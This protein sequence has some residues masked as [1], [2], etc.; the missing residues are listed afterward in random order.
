GWAAR[1]VRQAVES[2]PGI[3]DHQ[4]RDTERRAR[5]I[6]DF[7]RER[8]APAG[9]AL[10]QAQLVIARALG[11]ASWPALIG[12]VEQLVDRESAGS[13]FERAADA[14]VSGDLPA[15]ERLLA[16]HPALVRERSS[17]EHRATLLHYVS[18]NGV[19]SWRQK[20]PPNAVDVARLL[21]DAGA[22]VDAEADV[23]G[24]GATTLGLVVTSAHPRAAG[25]QNALADLLL[26][27]GARMHARVAWYCLMNGCPEAAAHVVERG[28]PLDLES[29]AGIGRL[30]YV[31]RCFEPPRAPSPA[32]VAAAL[33]MATW[34]DR[35]DVVRHLLDRG[36]NLAARD[37]KDGSTP[38]HLAAYCG[39]SAVVE[40]LLSR[41]A[42]VDALDAERA[43]PLAWVLHAR[44]E[45]RRARGEY[46]AVLRALAA[47][48]AEVRPEWL[49]DPRV[50]REPDLY[51]A[52]ARDA[53]GDERSAPRE[54]EA[55]RA[56]GPPA[57]GE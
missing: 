11:F 33:R 13:A 5:Q 37:A 51:R 23:Y 45:E 39:N 48:G 35:R 44:L 40:L 36:A 47:A 56:E 2:H 18:A 4:R 42:A 9:C 25:V 41:G 54:P 57:R 31:A 50:R 19:E 14:I 15:L 16:Q 3:P 7:A 22:V 21:L 6:A 55:D 17:R 26:D 49:E 43:T 30:D 34:Y 46:P 24:G 8:L 20:T 28:A 1:W 52:L 12:H 53:A 32:E 29:A 27:R 10:S 38:L